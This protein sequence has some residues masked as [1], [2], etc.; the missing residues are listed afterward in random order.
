MG[1]LIAEPM[2]VGGVRGMGLLLVIV[3]ILKLAIMVTLPMY[4]RQVAIF[5]GMGR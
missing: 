5:E 3:R 4:M 1:V 2:A